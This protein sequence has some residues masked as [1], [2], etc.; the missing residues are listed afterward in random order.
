V[1]TVVND[2]TGTINASG[3]YPIGQTTVIWTVADIYGNI[4]SCSQIITVTDT[5]APTIT[6]PVPAASYDMDPGECNATLSFAAVG[7][8]NCG[9]DTITYSISGTDITFPY[10]FTL[11]TSTVTATVEDVNGNTSSCA[12]DVVVVDNQSPDISCPSNINTFTSATS[13]DTLVSIAGNGL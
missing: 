6:C 3:I 5:Q 13:C 10:D 11:G 2:F 9:V 12:F 1:A 8:D 7:S 4:D